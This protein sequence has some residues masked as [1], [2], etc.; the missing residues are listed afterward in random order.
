MALAPTAAVTRRGYKHE[1]PHPGS[2]SP[3]FHLVAREVHVLESP[4]VEY[5]LSRYEATC[6]RHSAPKFISR[7][8]IERLE[9][10]GMYI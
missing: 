3:R 9:Q 6:G 2:P 4:R 5:R 7:P 8:G 10:D 1:P